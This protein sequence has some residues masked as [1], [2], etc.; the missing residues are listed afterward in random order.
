MFSASWNKKLFQHYSQIMHLQ[1]AASVVVAA[2]R[3]DMKVKQGR[4]VGGHH[5]YVYTNP[6]ICVCKSTDE[7]VC[8]T[9]ALFSEHPA[10]FP[11][12]FGACVR[13][14]LSGGGLSSPCNWVSM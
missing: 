13:R 7:H 6:R 2:G 11:L 3:A 12:L 8:M 14:R 5:L 4:Y 1:I 9:R 10:H